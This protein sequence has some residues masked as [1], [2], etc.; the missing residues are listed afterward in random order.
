MT[1]ETDT[2]RMPVG[3]TSSELQLVLTSLRLLLA[4]EDDPAVIGE[5]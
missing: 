4:A 5:L 1:D 3:L 2:R